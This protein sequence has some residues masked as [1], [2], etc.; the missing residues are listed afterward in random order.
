MKLNRLLV[1]YQNIGTINTSVYCDKFARLFLVWKIQTEQSCCGSN[2]EEIDW[3]TELTAS[4][5]N[6][7]RR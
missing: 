4:D 3:E 7:A 2:T 5:P 1:R 6:L